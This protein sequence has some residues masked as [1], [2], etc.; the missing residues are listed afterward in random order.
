[1]QGK[2]Q[3]LFNIANTEKKF[4]KKTHWTREKKDPMQI[5][6]ARCHDIFGNKVS[7]RGWNSSGTI[8]VIM[9]KRNLTITPTNRRIIIAWN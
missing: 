9:T 4:N 2:K 6:H 1:M 7:I 5:L 8:V 3:T